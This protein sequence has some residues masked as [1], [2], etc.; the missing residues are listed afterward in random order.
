[1]FLMEQ[2]QLFKAVDERDVYQIFLADAAY[3]QPPLEVVRK[4]LQD[5]GE[6]VRK[7]WHDKI[8]QESVRLS[9]GALYAWDFQTEHIRLSVREGNKVTFAA[10]PGAAGSFRAAVRADH[11]KQRVLFKTLFV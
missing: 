6:C 1:M 5:H 4:D 8:R 3:R 7:V 11:K 10:S 9:A 2:E